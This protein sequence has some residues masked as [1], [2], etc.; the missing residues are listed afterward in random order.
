MVLSVLYALLG[1]IIVCEC[2]RFSDNILIYIIQGAAS[3]IFYSF[4]V[5]CEYFGITENVLGNL[6]LF[7][8]AGS[9]YG[10]IVICKHY[11]ITAD[12]LNNLSSVV[13]I[14]LLLLI[15]FIHILYNVVRKLHPFRGCFNFLLHILT[16]S[17]LLCKFNQ[18]NSE[19]KTSKE[20]NITIILSV[21]LA[22]FFVF[23]LS[24]GFLIRS[25]FCKIFYK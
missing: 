6:I 10:F 12:I 3:K 24:L 13:V 18:I 2:Y 22:V 15:E 1:F 9:F 23:L 16:I 19:L 21:S 25:L 8:L 11:G 17:L 5:I 7:A 4:L 14:A 20:K